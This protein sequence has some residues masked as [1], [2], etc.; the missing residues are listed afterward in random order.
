MCE[1]IVHTTP[2]AM[3][4]DS[5]CSRGVIPIIHNPYYGYCFDVSKNH[6]LGR[7]YDLWRRRT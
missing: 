3:T 7:A 6:V 4:T 5:R 1:S 2:T